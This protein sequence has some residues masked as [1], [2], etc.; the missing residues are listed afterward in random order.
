MSPIS[1]VV[2]IL[3]L[4]APVPKG[5]SAAGD[6]PQWRGPNRDDVSLETGL[7]KKW[8]EGGPKLAWTFDK[9]GVGFSSPVIAAGHVYLLGSEDAAKGANEFLLCL[10]EKDG[11]EAWRVPLG[12]GDGNYDFNWGNG[13]RSTV[14]VDGDRVY[15]LGAKGDLLCFASA[16]GKQVWAKNLVKNFGGKT[17]NWGYSESVLVDGDTVVCTPGGDKGT[18]LG[19]N[20]TTGELAWRS[21]DLTDGAG[22]SSIVVSEAAGVRHYVQQTMSNACGVRPGDGK[23]LWKRADIAYAIAVIPTPIVYKDSV[24]VTSGYNAKCA[25][26]KLSKSGDGLKA[27]SE[28]AKNKSLSNHH[29]GV[30]RVGEYIYGHDDNNGWVCLEFANAKST[31][32]P[33]PNW[34]S[35][36]LGKG[37]VTFADGNLYCYSE[38]KGICALVRANPDKWDEVSR[39]KIHSESKIPRKGG[40]IRTHPVVANGKLYLRDNELLFCYDVSD[41]K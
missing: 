13:P 19:L 34:K 9:A 33:E 24:F 3:S 35:K 30:V 39:F 23:L 17:P 7:L 4:T 6:W 15:A 10:S 27:E 12:T 11:K 38:G 32:G 37:S 20:K 31:D 21:T 22:Y 40:L 16:D 14:T 18:M 8:P 1:L 29:G 28:Y 41:R 25:L 5:T 36:D 26:I 2:L